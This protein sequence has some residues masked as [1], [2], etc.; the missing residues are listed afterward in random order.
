ME[1]DTR[2]I[3]AVTEAFETFFFLQSK[4]YGNTQLV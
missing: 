3:K 2:E 1:S 4:N